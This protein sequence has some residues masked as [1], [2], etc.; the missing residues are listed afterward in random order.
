[1]SLNVFSI[2]L[3]TLNVTPSVFFVEHIRNINIIKSKC[4][5]RADK[6]NSTRQDIKGQ[7]IGIIHHHGFGIIHEPSGM[8]NRNQM[9]V[10]E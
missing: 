2:F 10:K 4:E 1:M 3:G 8:A 6:N 9:P 5:P 7:F